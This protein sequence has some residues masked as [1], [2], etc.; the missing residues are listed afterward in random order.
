MFRSLRWQLIAAFGLVILLVVLMSGALSIWTTLSRFDLLVTEEGQA[1]AEQIAPLLEAS[2]AY[3]GDWHGLDDILGSLAQAETIPQFFESSIW[4]S[5]VDWWQ[6]SASTLGLSDDEL[7]NRVMESGSIAAVAEERGGDGGVVVQAIIQA[8]RDAFEEAGMGED[9]AQSLDWVSESATGFVFTEWDD[10]DVVWWPDWYAVAAAELGMDSEELAG[11][12]AEGVTIDELAR[13]RDVPPQQ[14][15]EA[16]LQT[17]EKAVRDAGYSSDEIGA[18]LRD[19]EGNVLAFL[20]DSWSLGEYEPAPAWTEEGAYWLLNNLLLSHNRLLVADEVGRVIFDSKD[21]MW[22]EILP[23]SMLYQGTSL[24]DQETDEYIGTVI[25]AA[26][27]GFY[28]AHQMAFLL[29]VSTSLAVSG[30]VAGVLAL[31]VGLLLARRITAPVTALTEASRRVADGDWSARVPVRSGDELGQM[32]AAFNKMA[33]ELGSQRDLRH[34]LVDAVAH[35]LS[36]PLSV[37]QLEIE[38]MRDRMQSPDRAAASVVREIDLLRG[39][40]DDLALLAE[41][42]AGTLQVHPQPTDLVTLVEQ[43]RTRWQPQADAA[44]VTLAV[45]WAGPEDGGPRMLA[46]PTRIGQVLGNLLSNALR[47]TPPGGSV[48]VRVV[49][50]DEQA[51]VTLH[52]TGEG[53]PADDLLHVFERFYRVDRSRS[54]ETGGHGLGLSIVRQVIESHGGRV[55]AESQVGAGSAFGFSLPLA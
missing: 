5:D 25:V 20:E 44:G 12:L 4:V 45:E 24:F 50:A 48:T 14:L 51:H 36:T 21:E 17:E 40:V 42:D 53:I 28:D 13:R 49:T 27:T 3:W 39:L 7:E 41:T 33:E 32:S 2:Y 18:Y 55:W 23:H 29:G 22:G 9:A 1:Q 37:I 52:D 26:G 30:L 15:V 54:R 43:A 19:V 35:E 46:D 10:G 34:R 16:I 8:E 38:A 47:H 31:V 6:V 11:A